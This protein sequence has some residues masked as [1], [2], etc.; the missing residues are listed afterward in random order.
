MNYVIQ[1][2]QCILQQ[3]AN[4]GIPST[5]ELAEEVFKSY[6]TRGKYKSNYVLTFFTGE[7][8]TL[9]ELLKKLEEK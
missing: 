3:L 8:I 6:Q 9:H 5:K 7:Q 4:F 1:A 2:S